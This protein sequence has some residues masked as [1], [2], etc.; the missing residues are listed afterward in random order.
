MTSKS[1]PEEPTVARRRH[2]AEQ[3]SS[4]SLVLLGIVGLLAALSLYWL[5]TSGR[6]LVFGSDTAIKRPDTRAIWE[7]AGKPVGR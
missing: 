3:S 1:P 6:E 2:D 5:R 4:L 7:A